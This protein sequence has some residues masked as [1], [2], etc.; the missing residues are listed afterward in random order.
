MY[1]PKF[2]LLYVYWLLVIAILIGIASLAFFE[3]Q[4]IKDYLTL[5]SYNPPTI[6]QQIAKQDG[7]TA[8]TKRV[9]YVNEPEFLRRS[10]FSRYC[11]NTSEQ[12]VVLGCYHLNQ[13]GIFLL[14]V[15]DPKLYGIEQVTAAYETLHAIYQRLSQSQQSTLNAEL[16]AFENHGLNNP[17]IKAQIANFRKTEPGG[18]L[19]E[20]TSLFGTEVNNL[21]PSLTKFYSQYF[22]NRQTLLNYYNDYESAFTSR[23]AAIANYD[24]Q[25][26]SLLSTIDADKMQLNTSLGELT[27]QRNS[28]TSLKNNGQYSLYNQEITTYNNQ[29]DSYNQLVS[30]TANLINQYNQIVSQRNSIVL[31]EQQLTQDITSTP[32][33]IA[34]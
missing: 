9:F 27:N 15:N 12:L 19:N 17:G 5:L 29:V 24:Q 32:S 25:L 16:I 3:R 31:E 7:M 4:N 2:K 20:M 1:K 23:Q 30:T 18:V 33:A 28:L 6:I 21:P 26:S 10:T 13:N 8:Y 11:P 34:R 14:S 22:T